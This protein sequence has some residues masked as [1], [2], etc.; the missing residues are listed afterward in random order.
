MWSD[1]PRS[2][3]Q[4]EDG[5]VSAEEWVPYDDDDDELVQPI[6]LVGAELW[7]EVRLPHG[8]FNLS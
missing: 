1:E 8:S 5:R 2:L 4:H 6:K 3:L 7:F